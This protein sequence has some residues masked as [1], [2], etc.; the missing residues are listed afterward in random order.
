VANGKAEPQ[1]SW[2]T[3]VGA[4]SV[5]G[6]MWAA[7]WTIFQTQFNNVEKIEAAD[8]ERLATD[9]NV[10]KA[11]TQHLYESLDKYLT[12]D[13]HKAYLTGTLEQLDSL[14]AR[15]TIVETQQAVLIAR[16]AHDPVEDKT[17]QAV[18]SAVGKQ[19]DQTQAQIADINRQIAAALIIIDNNAGVRKP[20]P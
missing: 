11:T 13:E 17:F 5:V 12:K 18:I 4:I 20:P 15:L 1:I 10:T 7:Q 19:I 14:R 3:I 6:M 16:L 9:F 8:R 2:M